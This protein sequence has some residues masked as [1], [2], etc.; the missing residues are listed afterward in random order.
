MRIV[1]SCLPYSAPPPSPL[2]SSR[3][4]VGRRL[5]Q[6]R[7]CVADCQQIASHRPLLCVVCRGCFL[8]SRLTSRTPSRPSL[9]GSVRGSVDRRGQPRVGKLPVRAGLHPAAVFL[10]HISC[11]TLT[12]RARVHCI[13][14]L[15]S[16]GSF[17]LSRCLSNCNGGCLDY[18]RRRLLASKVKAARRADRFSTLHVSIGASVLPSPVSGEGKRWIIS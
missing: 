16:A 3:G 6:L 18:A 10:F 13:G 17:D 12:R 14:S 1:C 8:Y 11:A 2:P 7:C 4:I 15:S 9:R 5:R